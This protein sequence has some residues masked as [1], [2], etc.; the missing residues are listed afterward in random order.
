MK[1]YFV[2]VNEDIY[3]IIKK[4]ANLEKRSINNM[5]QILLLDALIAREELEK[6]KLVFNSNKDV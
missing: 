1:K 5:T 6:A 2:R 4:H 3:E